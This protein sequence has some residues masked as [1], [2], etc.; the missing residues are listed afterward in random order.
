ME[1]LWFRKKEYERL[2]VALDTNSVASRL[3]PLVPLR[4]AAPTP[5]GPARRLPGQRARERRR[6]VR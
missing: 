4:L 2:L 5:G 1:N 3:A 6:T